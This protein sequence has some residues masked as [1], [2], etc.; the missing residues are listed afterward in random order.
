[1]IL[2]IYFKRRLVSI[3]RRNEGLDG[4]MAFYFILEFEFEYK[5]AI[6]NLIVAQRFCMN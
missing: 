4:Y 5:S 3:V 1:M 6:R 2:G